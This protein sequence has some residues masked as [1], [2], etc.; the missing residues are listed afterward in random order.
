MFHFGPCFE[1]YTGEPRE[2][3]IVVRERRGWR[4]RPCFAPKQNRRLELVA[5]SERGEVAVAQ[6]HDIKGHE[7]HAAQ[8]ALWWCEGFGQRCTAF[9]GA[10]SSMHMNIASWSAQNAPLAGLP[11]AFA[12]AP[13]FGTVAVQ[14]LFTPRPPNWIR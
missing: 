7:R 6:T 9:L 13:L 3:Q 10:R 11:H 2:H 14:R 1:V 4:L 8:V 12:P 5:G